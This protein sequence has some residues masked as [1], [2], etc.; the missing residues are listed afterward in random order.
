LSNG[1]PRNARFS[2]GDPLEYRVARFLIHLGF[3]VRRGREIYTIGDLDQATDLDVFAVRYA[4]M[5]RREVQIC[6]CKSGREGP[7]DRVFWIVGVKDYVGAARATI[8]RKSTKWNIKDFASRAGVEI[9]DL[10]RLESL[11]KA[12]GIEPN[13]WPSIS[14][15]LFFQEYAQEWN[16][17]LATDP[18]LR[19]LYHTLAGEVRFHEPLSAVSFL[20]H[21]ARALTREL[22][23]SRRAPESLLKFLLSDVIAHLAMFC[24]RIAEFTFNLSETDR[25]GY[26]NKGL[27]YGG[28]DAKLTERIFR[29][30]QRIAAESVKYYTGH[31]VRL[32]PSLFQMPEPPNVAEVQELVRLLVEEP[33]RSSTFGP[34]TD[35][36]LSESYLKQ[37][38]GSA[39]LGKIFPYTDLRDRLALVYGYLAILRRI[40]AIPE[41][42]T[43]FDGNNGAQ[44]AKDSANSTDT[45]LNKLP[46][47]STGE[48]EQR[49][50][51]EQNESSNAQRKAT[52]EQTKLDTDK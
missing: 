2:I 32:D 42:K 14:N 45:D 23:G 19:E 6:E 51:V 4:D 46:T 28:L 48:S 44:I 36:V 33:L 41:S 5:F 1:L 34:M 17:Y 16:K 38:K 25:N 47:L 31:D 24:M 12:I 3:F 7:L 10:P 52:Q 50:I 15:R 13:Y 37:G 22:E 18:I 43:H 11:E 21:H 9:I 40:G 27:T 49:S 20:L 8:V 39:T 30:A 35:L 29:N 26:I